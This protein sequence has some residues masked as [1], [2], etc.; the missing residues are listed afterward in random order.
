MTSHKKHDPQPTADAADQ[1]PTR[2]SCFVICPIG[3][4]DSLTRRATNGLLDDVIIPVCSTLGFDTV[5]AHRIEESGDIT[6]QIVQ[7]LLNC[8]LVVCNLTD[9]NPNV[10]YEL[11]IRHAVRRPVVI[12]AHEDGAVASRVRRCACSDS[13]SRA[14]TLSQSSCGT[15]WSL[16]L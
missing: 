11:A 10:M 14:C 13:R 7:R 15:S 16:S 3:K 8:D 6:T 1:E 12:I 9:L 4:S 5:A 2:K